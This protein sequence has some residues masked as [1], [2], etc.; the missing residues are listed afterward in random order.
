MRL[1]RVRYE[2]G[3]LKPLGD[4][5]LEEAQEFNIAV[6]E[7]DGYESQ[8][9]SEQSAPGSVWGK[10]PDGRD[11]IEVIHEARRLGTRIPQDP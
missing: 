3:V 2:D 7:P 1:L 11:P 4:H 10:K 6:P 9:A 5:C 8:L